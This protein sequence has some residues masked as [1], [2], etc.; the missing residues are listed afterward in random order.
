MQLTKPIIQ[1]NAKSLLQALRE[2]LK[3]KQD[4]RKKP[5]DTWRHREINAEITIK[6]DKQTGFISLISITSY[7]WTEANITQVFDVVHLVC[8]LI[9]PDFT[10]QDELLEAFSA[11]ADRTSD[12]YDRDKT[13]RGIAF[14][15]SVNPGKSI[16]VSV[17]RHP[18][19]VAA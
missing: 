2:Q 1:C 14:C 13:I 7:Q 8:R 3:L 15:Q 17:K 18:A 12:R 6:T 9:D 19:V 16:A 10:E 11:P 5:G 4:W